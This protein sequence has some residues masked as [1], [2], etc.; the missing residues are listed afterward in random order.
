MTRSTIEVLVTSL[1][2]VVQFTLY[3]IS[4]SMLEQVFLR[5]KRSKRVIWII[6][7]I[8]LRD[9]QMCLYKK[10]ITVL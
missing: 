6:T 9:N 7:R 2:Y 1:L 10:L 8:D 3:F 5:K 4:F